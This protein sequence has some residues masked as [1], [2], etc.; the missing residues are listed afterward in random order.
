MTYPAPRCIAPS[1]VLAPGTTSAPLGI[2]ARPVP[3]DDHHRL[4]AHDPRVMPAG[5][6]GDVPRLGDH[7]AAVVHPDRELTTHVILE[8]RRLAAVGPSDRPDVIR[9]A[10]A[11]LKGHSAHFGATDRENLCPPVRKLARLVGLSKALVFGLV[12]H[13]PCPGR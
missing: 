5:Q 3:V 6:R 1:F 10:P 13:M 11:R 2:V 12:P 4:I 7:L 8:V 9:P